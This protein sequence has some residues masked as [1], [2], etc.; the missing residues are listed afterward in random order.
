MNPK[1]NYLGS[2]GSGTTPSVSSYLST[3]L[4]G[5]PFKAPIVQVPTKPVSTVTPSNTSATGTVPTK[6]TSPAGQNYMNSLGS[7]TNTS[8]TQTTSNTP[9]YTEDPNYK[10]YLAYKRDQENPS[11]KTTQVTQYEN[12]QKRLADIQSKK[13]KAEFDARKGLND[14]LDMSG[15]LKAGTRAGAGVYQNRSS[16]D[17]ANLALE[18]SAAARTAGVA[19]DVL[20]NYNDTNKKEGF[21]LGKD[22]TRYEYNPTTGAYESVGVGN[23]SADTTGSELLSP[24]EAQLL[25]VPYGTTKA[26][27]YGAS[28]TNKP[29]EEQSK[30]RQFAVTAKNANDLLAKSDYDLGYLEPPL[31]N[32]LKSEKRQAF[33]QASRALVNSVLRRESGATITD[34]E[35]SNKYKEI[36]PQAGDAPTVIAQKKLAREAAVKSIEEAG[37]RGAETQPSQ[38]IPETPKAGDVWK[39]PDG[40]QYQFK[41]GN[42]E[43]FNEVGNTTVSIPQT[44]RLAYVNNNPGNLRFAGQDG[45]QQGEGGFARFNSPQEG[46][47]ALQNQIK[48]DATRGLTLAQFI[49]KYAPPSENDTSKYIRDIL[50]ATGATPLTPLAS[51]DIMSLTKAIAQKESGTNIA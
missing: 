24:S 43:S 35:F 10:A 39:A 11:E 6:I 27:A 28:P 1:K 8:P 21:S 29:T 33:E 26:Q 44:S 18:E 50:N 2:L 31:P 17:I 13:D 20:K 19:T 42:W 51:I 7:S 47:Q 12:A 40:A 46:V 16:N 3:P 15:G 45:A 25:G 34:D 32:V 23:S 9:S 48:L 30:A 41:D 36:I 14:T 38:P 37:G 5:T 4:G 22:Q 49:N